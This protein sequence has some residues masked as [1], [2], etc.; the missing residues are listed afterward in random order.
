MI[1]KRDQD[2][3]NFVEDFHI[4]TSKQ[5]HRLFFP[6]TSIQYRCERLR[7]LCRE[8]LLKRTRSTI[9]NCYAYYVKKHS[10]VHHD[11]LRAELFVNIKAQYNL[12][13]W[14]NEM[15]IGSI[16]PDAL[17]YIERGLPLMIEIHLSNRFDFEK[18]DTD[19]LPVFGTH[20]RIVI[21]TDKTLR[22]PDRRYRIVTTD[23]QGLDRL[24]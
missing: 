17:A 7:Y 23:M 20:P 15:T 13:E 9:D 18:Y 12:L 11:L 8:K 4:A 1:T 3:I 10:Q 5:I 19:F 22:L 16:R 6:N 21:C 24:L 14:S 2:I